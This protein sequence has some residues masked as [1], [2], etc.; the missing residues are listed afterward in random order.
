MAHRAARVNPSY[1]HEGPDV[2]GPRPGRSTDDDRDRGGLTLE[3]LA[4]GALAA[5]ILA[6]LA[7]LGLGEAL[8]EDVKIVICR[9]VTLDKGPCDSPGDD[10]TEQPN[11]LPVYCDALIK[12]HNEG[13]AGTLDLGVF[14][15]SYAQNYSLMWEKL[16]NGEVWITIMPKDTSHNAEVKLGDYV[17]LG[18]DKHA[19]IGDTYQFQSDAEANKWVD[20]LRNNVNEH[21]PLSWRFWNPFDGGETKV[22]KP[23]IHAET[24]GYGAHVGGNLEVDIPLEFVN[25]KFG[26][27]VTGKVG[28]DV[29]TEDWHLWD[30]KKNRYWDNTSLSYK[31]SGEI[32]PSVNGKV[33]VPGVA[34]VGGHGGQKYKWTS[35]IRYMYNPD[36]TI[37]NI[38]WITTYEDG[39]QG[40]LGSEAGPFSSGID[41]STTHETTRFTQLNF[42]DPKDAKDPAAKADAQRQ[43]KVARGYIDQHGKVLPMPILNAITGKTPG[44]TKDPGPN[45][46]PLTRMM[47]EKGKDWAWEADNSNAD[48]KYGLGPL[49]VH[50][51]D[52]TKSTNT[53]KYLGPPV[54]GHRAYLDFPA[55]EA[56]KVPKEHDWRL[57]GY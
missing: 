46:D 50:F 24:H 34:G 42:D 4:L 33:E 55:C 39:W 16:A 43:Q 1:R 6:T 2:H 15:Y 25:I 19:S 47:Y 30:P 18:G 44:V 36:G 27:G 51:D 48:K 29:V 52:L 54:D 38:R 7:V 13:P 53:A 35:T 41:G 31:I 9:I 12:T 8:G 26:E 11:F 37:A 22:K 57:D 5:I 14:K 28:R 20:T 32:D 17:N 49:S 3:Y 10:K 21:N 40:G 56:S 23:V 45:A